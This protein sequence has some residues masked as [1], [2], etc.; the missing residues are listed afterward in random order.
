MCTFFACINHRAAGEGQA[1]DISCGR[2]GPVSCFDGSAPPPPLPN[3]SITGEVL[4]QRWSQV[5][6]NSLRNLRILFKNHPELSWYHLSLATLTLQIFE[7]DQTDLVP[8]HAGKARCLGELGTFLLS[9]AA[10][11]L[12]CHCLDILGNCIATV[13]EAACHGLV[14]Q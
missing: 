5:R 3:R 6:P 12:G 11:F 14:I 9:F 2:V 10:G 7:L 8:G 4:G 1:W 13:H